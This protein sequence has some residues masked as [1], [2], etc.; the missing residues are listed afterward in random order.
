MNTLKASVFFIVLFVLA[1]LI[2]HPP[3]FTPLIAAAIFIPFITKDMRVIVS[4]PIIVMFVADYLIGFHEL[5]LWTYGAFLLISISGLKY[6]NG[7]FNRLMML[8]LSSP[9]IFYLLTNFGV[10]FGSNTYSANIEGLISCYVAGL[11]F[12]ANSIAACLLFS[13]AFFMVVEINKKVSSSPV[14]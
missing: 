11:P 13:A 14:R 7:K 5:M 10:W 3:N 8:S 9:T 4:L 12:Y 6:F 2:P 1:R